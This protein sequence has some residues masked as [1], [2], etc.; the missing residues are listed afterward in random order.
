MNFV[1]I[2]PTN[3][4][5]YIFLTNFQVFFSQCSSESQLFIFR[6]YAALQIGVQEEIPN[7]IYPTADG[8]TS[9]YRR[10]REEKNL[11]VLSDLI[12]HFSEASRIVRAIV[13]VAH[14]VKESRRRA[15]AEQN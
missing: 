9:V 1:Y 8:I 7:Y 6:F 13:R 11:S 12:T 14:T 3:F 10:K 2:F 5:S 4:L 15:P